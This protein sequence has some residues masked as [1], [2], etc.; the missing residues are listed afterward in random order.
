M[1]KIMILDCTL[2]DGGYI[3]GWYFGERTIKK[4][5]SKLSKSNIDIIE[6]GFLEEED[7]DENK[8][9]YNSVERI[10]EYIEPKNENVMYVGMIAQPYIIY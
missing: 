10:R 4:I 3:N 5:I 7:F 2:R 9:L 6:C 8:T 1:S